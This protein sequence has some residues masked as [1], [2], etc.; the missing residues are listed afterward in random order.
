MKQHYETDT[1]DVMAY[2]GP[3]IGLDSFEVG[4]EVYDAFAKADFPMDTIAR[5]YKDSKVDDMTKWHI[6][7]W[8]ANR[9]QL[10]AKGVDEENIQVAGICTCLN[11]DLFFSARKQGVDSGRMLTAIM[12]R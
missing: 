6:D 3:G 8:E 9:I 4:Q 2:I 11:T 5:R 7:L 10:L 12:I 1:R